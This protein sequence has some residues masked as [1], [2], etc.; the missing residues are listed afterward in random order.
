[1]VRRLARAGGA[2]AAVFVLLVVCLA[3]DPSLES[4][5]AVSQGWGRI[6][7]GV[8]EAIVVVS[9]DA[10]L[11]RWE[12]SGGGGPRWVCG[13]YSIDAPV[14]SV[15]DPTPV[16]NWLVRVAPVAGHEYMFACD[17]DDGAD[18]AT[19]V[20]VRYVR[21][22]PGD[23]FSGVGGTERALDEARRRLP[24]PDP[25]PHLNPATEQLVGLPT[26]LWLERPWER[27]SAVAS[28]GDAWAAVAAY[29][30]LAHW[31]FAD[32]TDIYCDEGIPYDVT[33]PAREQHSGCT[34]TFQHSSIAE[35]DAIEWVRVTMIW[36][37]EWYSAD[38]GGQPM[39]TV[40]RSTDVPVR[41]VEA[42]A[43]VR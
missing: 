18:G 29:P 23:I 28:I 33:R 38:A 42:Q 20:E 7:G 37:V 12:S 39:G 13:Y 5:G 40:Q 10:T 30:V 32:G 17:V 25:D 26:W 6:D 21:Y 1:M 34:H 24:V 31:T 2:L 27:I 14:H 36:K 41:V 22:D 43:L 9:E 8:P 3:V 16:V 19:R 11:A 4:A 35:P 15:L